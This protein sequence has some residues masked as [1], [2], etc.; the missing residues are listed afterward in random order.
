M[1][2]DHHIWIL[3]RYIRIRQGG[4]KGTKKSHVSTLSKQFQSSYIYTSIISNYFLFIFEIT[5]TFGH[6]PKKATCPSCP[7]KSKAPIYIPLNSNYFLFI[8]EITWTLGHPPKKAPSLCPPCPPNFKPPHYTS[9]ISNYFLFIFNI[10]WTTWTPQP[11]DQ[12][13]IDSIPPPQL[14]NFCR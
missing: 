1:D 2:G 11:T 4:L 10:H 8:F 5:W 9:L 7:S 13:K 6:P 14:G 3:S 12:K